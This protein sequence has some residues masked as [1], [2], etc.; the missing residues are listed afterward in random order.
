[1]I[2]NILVIGLVWPEPTSSAAGTRMLQLLRFFLEE[3][4][5][6]T[7]ASAAQPTEYSF[8][9]SSIGVSTRQIDLNASSFDV[10]VRELQPDIVLFDRYITEEQFGWR[11]ADSVPNAIR[12]LDTEDLHCLRA[13]RQAS[14]KAGKEFSENDLLQSPIALREIASIYRCDLSLMISE[15]EVRFLT[16]V[17]GVPSTLLLYVPFLYENIS[18]DAI[19]QWPSF[20]ERNDYLFIGNF[21]HYPNL[22]AVRY[23]RAS[24]WPHIR[25]RHSNAV[26][27]IHG[28]YV[29]QEVTQCH[30][31]QNGFLVLGRAADVQSVMSEA[32]VLLAPLRIGAGQKGK[33]AEAMMF[34]L[35]VVSTSVGYEG[36]YPDDGGGC[37]RCDDPATFA[38]QADLLYHDEVTWK[39]QQ[40]AGIT[41]FRNLFQ[42]GT[43]KR[44]LRSAIL[45]LK[46][47]LESRRMQN[48]TGRMLSHHTM[49]AHRYLSKW[50]EEKHRRNQ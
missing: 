33:L 19:Q 10:F 27:R 48:F 25:A 43:H 11:V 18:E 34:G 15:S 46:N 22:D 1:M 47:D 38:A 24:I 50:I 30:D 13:A 31:P 45:D 26:I 35:P 49:S 20:H 37:M 3:G 6:L 14:V 7:F 32:R 4:H 21:L 44:T 28:A 5:S 12:L 40:R 29:T 42:T 41:L 17:L 23:L 39:E 16:S 9:L 8:P 2:Q 36:M